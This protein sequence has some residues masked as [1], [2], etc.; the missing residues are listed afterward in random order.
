[1][2]DQI[3][4]P[5][6]TEEAATPL[7]LRAAKGDENAFSQLVRL[8]SPRIARITGA[9]QIPDEEKE[10][11]KQEALLG[12]FKA[13]HLFDPSLSSFSTFGEICI[14]SAVTD[15]LRRYARQG[16][17][18][19]LT[20]EESDRIPADDVQSPE[21]ILLGKEDLAT[22]LRRSDAL[23]SPLER[24]IFAMSIGGNSGEEIAAALGK[25]AKSIHNA[26]YR[27]RRKLSDLK[28]R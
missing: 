16:E 27:I 6:V 10:D 4:F 12:L 11:L 7:A 25:E 1:M 26:L 20:E 13:V 15:G 3:Q 9:L 14:R 22:L 24:R 18:S 17:A 8:F 23:P 21:R 2:S 28:A 19:L 5:S